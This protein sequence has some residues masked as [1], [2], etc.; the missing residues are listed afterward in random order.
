MTKSRLKALIKRQEKMIAAHDLA[1]KNLPKGASTT[2]RNIHRHYMV[3]ALENLK[4]R[5]KDEYE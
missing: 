2:D 4:K 1:V 5:L 3:E